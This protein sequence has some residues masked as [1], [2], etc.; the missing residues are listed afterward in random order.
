MTTGLALFERLTHPFRGRSAYAGGKEPENILVI[1]LVGLGD[2]VLM[3]TP[4]RKL[5]DTFPRARISALVTPL[6]T[7]IL[8]GQPQL[9]SLIIHDVLGRDRGPA[10][11]IRLVRRLRAHGFDCVLDFEQHFQMT[12]IL[13]YLINAPRRIGLYY[14]G[15]PR[16]H[17]LTDPVFLDPDR[18]MVDTYMGLLGPLGIEAP[19]VEVLEPVWIDPADT[20]EAERWLAARR[21]HREQPLVGIHAGS[22]IRAPERRW[23]RP[24]FAEIIRRISAEYG[25]DI[26]LTGNASEI[27]LVDDILKIAGIADAF[28]AAGCL[29]IKQTAALMKMCDLFISNDTG[30]MH[31]AASVGTPTLGLFGPNIPRRYAP[32]GK[33]TWSIFKGVECSP[34]IHI[35][36]GIA[37]ECGR[38]I[39]MEAISVEEVWQAIRAARP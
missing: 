39:C 19:P 25:A 36:K 20:C 13:S 14:T 4:L 5:R 31:I 8:E 9:D 32:V 35:H 30:P 33:R 22:G 1:K 11:F 12:A 6:S 26:V 17:L 2:T 10:G 29:T 15:N 18:H 23:A 7:G 38:G 37:G 3:L 28:S 24:R 27:D 34:C 16:R 21:R